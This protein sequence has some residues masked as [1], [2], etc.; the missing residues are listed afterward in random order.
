MTVEFFP[1][2]LLQEF[3]SEKQLSMPKYCDIDDQKEKLTLIS[4]RDLIR[5]LAEKADDR[6]ILSKFYSSRIPI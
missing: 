4:I 5:I 6:R 3:R 1:N 2:S